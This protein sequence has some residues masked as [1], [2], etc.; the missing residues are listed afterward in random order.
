MT[1]STHSLSCAEM[2]GHASNPIHIE[3]DS[4]SDTE[5]KVLEKL[6][7]KQQPTTAKIPVT[8]VGDNFTWSSPGFTIG[9]SQQIELWKQR[10]SSRL[11]SASKQSSGSIRSVS[12]TSTKTDTE[13]DSPI[14]TPTH[15]TSPPTSPDE[16]FSTSDADNGTPSGKS[17]LQNPGRK[18]SGTTK[19]DMSTITI[20]KRKRSSGGPTATLG[21]PKRGN[22]SVGNLKTPVA[23]RQ[24]VC[25]GPDS[26]PRCNRGLNSQETSS[27]STDNDCDLSTDLEGPTLTE[28]SISTVRSEEVELAKVS[29]T[30]PLRQLKRP[31]VWNSPYG[32][33]MKGSSLEDRSV[34]FDNAASMVD[35]EPSSPPILSD[36]VPGPALASIR[37]SNSATLR[38]RCDASSASTED[39]DLVNDSSTASV[40]FSVHENVSLFP[41]QDEPYASSTPRTVN[42]PQTGIAEPLQTVG[43]TV[44]SLFD[45][46][47]PTREAA[48]PEET[49]PK[50]SKFHE[51]D[52]APSDLKTK[53]FEMISKQQIPKSKIRET[54]KR[55]DGDGLGSIYIYTSA[56][57]PGFFKVGKT[58]GPPRER[59]KKWRKCGL[60]I[61]YLGDCHE[62]R[63]KHFDIVERL[64]QAELYNF[65][66]KFTCRKDKKHGKP[67]THTEWFEIDGVTLLKVVKRWQK[68]I[69]EAEPFDSE[70]K[71]APRWI[72][73]KNRM[74]QCS[75]DIDLAKWTEPMVGWELWKYR[76]YW[77]TVMFA[78]MV[79]EMKSLRKGLTD[80]QQL[81]SIAITWSLFW[82]MLGL[83]LG[84]TSFI[85][86][87]VYTVW[88]L[89]GR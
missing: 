78:T 15:G 21:N 83:R 37:T 56:S 63:F 32:I 85:L 1:T 86:L 17:S 5:T 82:Y 14:S 69:I 53:L 2:S 38:Y 30:Q 40:L 66:R 7:S 26:K 87:A 81:M 58:E 61:S 44:D 9:T 74:A 59:V 29:V 10:R 89:S 46:E 28:T 33:N 54:T 12:S 39:R 8:G 57:C 62:K 25:S 65:R 35:W 79:K 73:R 84:S 3:S 50:F 72:W 48:I 43:A 76:G 49:Y 42:I 27:V 31:S 77:E 67:T 6:L 68:W 52:L 20:N 36:T 51:E 64:V 80:A 11:S 13:F 23:L 47:E 16:D 34:S 45:V 4:S 19:S 71:V 75:T 18:V 88:I 22:L 70:G 55:K 60:E 24:R 41:T